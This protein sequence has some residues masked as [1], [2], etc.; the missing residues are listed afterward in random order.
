MAL[1]HLGMMQNGTEV[2]RRLQTCATFQ[3]LAP[4]GTQRD[5]TCAY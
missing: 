2:C 3:A 5:D 4:S 1:A